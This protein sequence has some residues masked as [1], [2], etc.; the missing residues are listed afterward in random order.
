GHSVSTAPAAP[1]PAAEVAVPTPLAAAEPAEPPPPQATT[2]I[3]KEAGN[4]RLPFERARLERSIASIH[5]EFPQ[6][7]V[8]DYTRSVCGFV[9][10][11]DSVNA[12]DLVDHLIREAEARVDL[13]AP[14]W[15]YF[16]ARIYLRRL[17]KRASRNRFYDAGQKYGSYVGLQE[18]LADRNLYSNDILRAYSKE[19]LEEAGRMIEPDRDLLFTYNGL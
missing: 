15:E 13:A 11:K 12:D 5:A 17:Y 8:A 7:D 1:V 3:T 19:E 16:A 10:R 9:E 14:E 2:W 6:L 18:S 4:R